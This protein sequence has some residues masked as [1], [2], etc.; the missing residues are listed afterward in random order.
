MLQRSPEAFAEQVRHLD[1]EGAAVA[2]KARL[3]LAGK[4]I[5]AVAAE[6]VVV[7]DI[8]SRSRIRG[9]AEKKLALYV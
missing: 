4:R 3:D 5:E 8:E 9:P 2:A 6:I 7:T 1:E